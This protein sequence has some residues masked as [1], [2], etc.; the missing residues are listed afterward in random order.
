MANIKGLKLMYLNIRSLYKHHDELFLNCCDFDMICIGETWLN[1]TIR[2]SCISHHNFT[3]F[4][5]DRQ[6]PKRGGGL[7]V[8]MKANYGKYAHIVCNCSSSNNDLEQLWIEIDI[9]NHKKML[10]VNTYR[11]PS[12]NAKNAMEQLRSTINRYGN[13]S[14]REL[15]IMGDLNID[16]LSSISTNCKELKE[17]CKDFNLTQYIKEPTRITSK[18]RTILDVIMTNMNF[19]KESGV[20]DIII[21]DHLP[22]YIIKKKP[23]LTHKYVYTESRNLKSYNIET[24]YTKLIGDHRWLDFWD[25]LSVTSMWNILYRIIL[26][27]LNSILPK[28]RIRIKANNPEWFTKEVLDIITAK[29]KCFRKAKNNPG[30][31]QLWKEYR[32]SNLAAKRAVQTSKSTY[33]K[34]SLNNN[35]TDPKKFWNEISKLLGTSKDT[36]RSIKTIRNEN[37]H[38]V[39]DSDAAEYMNDYYVNIGAKLAAMFNLPGWEPHS[40]FPRQYINQF[41]FR[42][43]TEKECLALI[44]QI[45]ISKSSATKDIKSIFLKDAF[46]KLNFEISYMLNRSLSLSEFPTCWGY[47]MVTPIPKE[48]DHLD[49]GNWRPISQMPLIGRLLEKAIHTQL[50][51]YIN[52][53]G[54]LHRNQHGFRANKSTGSAIFQYVR[55]LFNTID[56][57]QIAGAIYIDYKKAFDTISHDI[58]LKKLELYGF[59]KHTLNWFRNYLSNRSQSTI[60]NGKISNSKSVAY[61]VPQGSTLGPTLFIM[62]VNDLFYLPDI[63]EENTIMYADDTVLIASDND[64]ESVTST[65]QTNIDTISSWCQINKLT[66]NESKTKYC[67]FNHKK[68]TQSFAPMCNGQPLG[69]VQSYKYLGVDITSD[70]GMDDYVSNVYRKA[71][72]KIHMLSKIRKY[73]TVHAATQIY[74]QTILPYLDYASFLMDSAYQYSLALLDKIQKRGIRLIEYE[75]EYRKRDN[76]KRL[77]TKYRIENIRHRRDLQL[78]SFMYNESRSAINLNQHSTSLLLRS[79]NKI[80]FKE[81]LTRKTQVQKSPY[82]RG[83]SLWNTLTEAT[84]KQGTLRKFKCVIKSSFINRHNKP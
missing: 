30:D 32:A 79:S 54:L 37:E 49:P 44:K 2:D 39:C 10:L 13:I 27:S 62:F 15:V 58:L 31:E 28:R 60:V 67:L 50:T 41:T 22:V 36:G 80:K 29:N 76:I 53:I 21:S 14:T 12:G 35:R 70:L 40:A 82:F 51:Y 25:S 1:R 65:L 84:Q 55:K 64:V 34:T 69:L 42:I 18:S 71:S 11:P 72:Y 66:I 48:G 56:N 83:I 68:D 33:I 26:D 46:L 6:G 20:L 74:K 73:I 8:Y 77:M 3:L 43:I 16:I 81:T 45:D 59:T 24:F 7:A 19:V 52:S 17:F 4:R 5:Q 9:P 61:G 63:C 47:S 75:K 78:L 23:R 57:E 38:I